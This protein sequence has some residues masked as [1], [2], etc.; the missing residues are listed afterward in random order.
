M[1]CGND[2]DDAD[3]ALGR[4]IRRW[5]ASADDVAEAVTLRR[6]ATTPKGLPPAPSPA[7]RSLL[8]SPL[9]DNDA[10]LDVPVPLGRSEPLG[11]DVLEYCLDANQKIVKQLAECGLYPKAAQYQEKGIRF[12]EQLTAEYGVAFGFDDEADMKERLV[13]LLGLCESRQAATRARDI[14]KGILRAP[15]A[16]LQSPTGGAELSP[17]A[18]A[19][20][21]ETPQIDSPPQTPTQPLD[22]TDRSCRAYHRLG[23]VNV[24]LG[25]LAEAKVFLEHA[26]GGRRRL[27][28]MPTTLVRES[29]Q[30][31]IEVCVQSGAID[32][33]EGVA[34]WVKDRLDREPT[35]VPTTPT[36]TAHEPGYA[37]GFDVDG[38]EFHFDSYDM[39]LGT[40]PVHLAVQRRDED[41]VRLM[42]GCLQTLGT[43]DTACEQRGMA[44]PL[45][46]AAST[47]L[48][49]LVA[50][51]V[52]AG[53]DLHAADA[54]G[55]TALHRCQSR[56]G[57]PDDGGCRVAERLVQM[58]PDLV[59]RT[60]AAGKTALFMAVEMG[61][62]DMVAFLLADGRADPKICHVV[63][64]VTVRSPLVAAVA[65]VCRHRNKIGIVRMLLEHGAD[66]DVP[67]LDGT[68]A[69]DWAGKA[70]LA[71]E[72]IQR[73]IQTSRSRRRGSLS[74]SASM[75]S[76]GGADESLGRKSVGSGRGRGMSLGNKTMTNLSSLTGSTAMTGSEGV[77]GGGVGSRTESS[78]LSAAAP[79]RPRLMVMAFRNTFSRGGEVGP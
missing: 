7:A 3:D 36:G 22:P 41:M 55:Q 8:S 9:A 56:G 29:A 63:G 17:A 45:L 68:T 57:G 52:D 79:S 61:N 46:M 74:A 60:D 14:L 76:S 37:Q 4:E 10:L 47:R 62:D 15:G 35:A 27:D 18:T 33:A 38:A 69:A 16:L 75:S 2:S 72:R 54:S 49:G 51:F 65:L 20:A 32:E 30:L 43:L 42:L 73:M 70:G 58:A 26:F 59:D 31:L 28:P 25:N 21:P 67:D 66:P 24:S 40:T 77:A 48:D 19:A 53:A 44:W 13:E 6:P 11:Q 71:R 34:Q 1:A 78:S 50:A 39:S 5:R 23:R 64:R 12:R